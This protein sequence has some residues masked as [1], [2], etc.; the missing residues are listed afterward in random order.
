MNKN[1]FYIDSIKNESNKTIVEWHYNGK[2]PVQ[3]SEPLW[4]T[5][6]VSSFGFGL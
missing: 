6:N 2:L 5:P 4:I 3:I 1:G